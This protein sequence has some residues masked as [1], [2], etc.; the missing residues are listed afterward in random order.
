MIT[1][2][3]PWICSDTIVHHSC[4]AVLSLARAQWLSP[5]TC[6]EKLNGSAGGCVAA[7]AAVADAHAAAGTRKE[8]DMKTK[9]GSPSTASGNLTISMS[10]RPC[11]CIRTGLCIMY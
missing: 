9:M 1:F 5:P 6:P 8:G 4:T 10:S 2:H 7:A 3:F 11:L